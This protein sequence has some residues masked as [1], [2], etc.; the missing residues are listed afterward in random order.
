MDMRFAKCTYFC[1]LKET[2][3]EFIRNPFQDAEH[4]IAPEV[5]IWLK[6][7]GITQVITGE[8]GSFAQKSLKEA[9]I[10]AVLIENNSYTMQGIM[11]KIGWEF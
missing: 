10:Q 6:L 4:H 5:V 11:D 3:P 7:Q 8:I 2:G 1:F 9:L